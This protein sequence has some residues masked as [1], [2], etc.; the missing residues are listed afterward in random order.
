METEN[1]RLWDKVLALAK[2]QGRENE[3]I[4]TVIVDPQKA[5]GVCVRCGEE[6]EVLR[7]SVFVYTEG[8]PPTAIKEEKFTVD[9]CEWCLNRVMGHSEDAL[10][11]MY[12]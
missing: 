4:K 5:N 7:F 11:T 1:V 6:G 3:V 2:T 12:C 8:Y 9:Y 10:K